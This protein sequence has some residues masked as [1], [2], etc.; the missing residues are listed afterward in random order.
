MMTNENSSANIY[1]TVNQCFS[2]HDL[3]H[4][5]IQL[6]YVT[7]MRYP[8]LY[9]IYSELHSL[10]F[11]IS[12]IIEINYNF[13]IVYYTVVCILYCIHM[14]TKRISGHCVQNLLYIYIHVFT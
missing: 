8:L 5:I 9:K 4:I 3:H 7:S 13:P 14:F 10:Y 11:I 6:Y 12:H 2:S 1:G